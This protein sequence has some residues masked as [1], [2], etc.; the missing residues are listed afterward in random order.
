VPF[1]T[2]DLRAGERELVAQYLRERGS[3]FGVEVV[4]MVVDVEPRQR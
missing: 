4:E 1:G 3:D 2:R